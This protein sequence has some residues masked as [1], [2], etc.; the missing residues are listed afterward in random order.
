MKEL[1]PY[2]SKFRLEKIR[3]SVDGQKVIP[4]NCEVID[5]AWIVEWAS[6]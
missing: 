3:E 5:I 1:N 6:K 2:F 4:A